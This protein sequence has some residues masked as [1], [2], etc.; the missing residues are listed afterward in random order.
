MGE[1]EVIHVQESRPGPNMKA[2]VANVVITHVQPVGCVWAS[3]QL[4]RC[5]RRSWRLQFNA[6]GVT[7]SYKGAGSEIS[8]TINSDSLDW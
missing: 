4:V 3:F 2:E 6:V 1:V 7:I 8:S 5:V